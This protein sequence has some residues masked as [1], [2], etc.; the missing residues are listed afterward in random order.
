[1]RDPGDF[2]PPLMLIGIVAATLGGFYWMIRSMRRGSASTYDL[3]DEC[4]YDMQATPERCPECGWKR[5]TQELEPGRIDVDKLLETAPH[6]H[7]SLRVPGPDEKQVVVFETDHAVDADTIHEHLEAR[8]IAC[9]TVVR[10]SQM[11]R[12]AYLSCGTYFQVIVWSNDA[13]DAATLVSMVTV[14]PSANDR[15]AEPT[16][17]A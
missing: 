7:V 15:H 14:K 5:P 10:E 2:I 3:C 11:Q 9:E 16:K 4:G 17:N 6:D 13:A 1:M 8:G 12:G